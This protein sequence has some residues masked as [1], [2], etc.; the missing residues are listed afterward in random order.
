MVETD[1]MDRMIADARQVPLPRQKQTE[2]G[3]RIDLTA[4]AREAEPREI[5]IPEATMTMLEDYELYVG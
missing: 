4:A 1:A 5:R 3:Q 2:D